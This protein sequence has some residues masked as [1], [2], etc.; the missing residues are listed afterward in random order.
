MGEEG[1]VQEREA[2]YES[3]KTTSEDNI[4]FGPCTLWDKI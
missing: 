4:R 2:E 3:G 1:V